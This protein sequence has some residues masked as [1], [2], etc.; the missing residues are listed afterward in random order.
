MALFLNKVWNFLKSLPGVAWEI[1]IVVVSVLVAVLA[2]KGKKQA[3]NKLEGAEAKKV[4]AV[5][6]QTQKDIAK[7]DQ[8]AINEGEKQKQDVPKTPEDLARDLNS[9]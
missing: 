4:D 1:L 2:L 3:E 9:I 5:L 7:R 8:E 6:E